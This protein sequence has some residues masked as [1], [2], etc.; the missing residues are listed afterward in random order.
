MVSIIFTF[1]EETKSRAKAS[2]YEEKTVLIK[3][4]HGDS[5]KETESAL[6]LEAR[7]MGAYQFIVGDYWGMGND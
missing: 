3:H 2:G 1:N 7:R 5:S 4:A 6:N